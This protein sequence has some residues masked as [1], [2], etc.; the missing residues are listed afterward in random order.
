M[1]A[2]CSEILQARINPRDPVTGIVVVLDLGA[3]WLHQPLQ[4][5]AFELDRNA[6]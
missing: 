4:L 6:S 3:L 2:S 1:A 5:R